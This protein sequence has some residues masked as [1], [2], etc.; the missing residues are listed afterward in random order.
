LLF[1][2]RSDGSIFVLFLFV[3]RSPVVDVGLA[4]NL[5]QVVVTKGDE[6]TPVEHQQLA[7]PLLHRIALVL[8]E[9]ISLGAL[10]MKCFLLPADAVLKG[11]LVFRRGRVSAILYRALRFAHQN[12]QPP[13]GSSLIVL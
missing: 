3:L 4:V 11:I 1:E 13:S 7:D 10:V 8:I 2:N 9:N 6:V 5:S 12:Y